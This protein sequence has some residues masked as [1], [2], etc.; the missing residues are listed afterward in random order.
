[1][2]LW[3]YPALLYKTLDTKREHLMRLLLNHVAIRV[4][5]RGK[6]AGYVKI[7]GTGSARI[8]YKVVTSHY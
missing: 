8:G 7:H 6:Y 5:G 2:P 4:K 1:M 3:D